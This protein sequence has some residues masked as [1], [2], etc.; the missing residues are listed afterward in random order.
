MDRDGVEEELEAAVE[1][2][3]GGGDDEVGEAGGGGERRGAGEQSRARRGDATEGGE[4]GMVQED[5]ME[6]VEE[7]EAQKAEAQGGEDR[8]EDMA[9]MEVRRGGKRRSLE[10]ETYVEHEPM[11]RGVLRSCRRKSMVG[12]DEEV[13]CQHGHGRHM[14]VARTHADEVLRE[15]DK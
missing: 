5:D 15:R 3:R 11:G 13:A 7:S 9:V 10:V 12:G 2:Q 4:G 8:G 14:R 1:L 6:V